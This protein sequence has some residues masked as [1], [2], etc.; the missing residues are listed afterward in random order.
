MDST[1]PRDV[2]IAVIGGSGLYS[3]DS[4][5]V[6]GEFEIPTPFGKPSDAITVASLHGTKIAFLARHGKGHH[7]NPSE[8]PSKANIAALKHIGVQVILAFSAVGSLREEIAPKDFVLPS[9]II[10][11]T[12][13]IRPSTF[14]EDGLV[15]H[16]MFADPFCKDISDLIYDVAIKIEGAPKIHH[17][18][19]I[20]CMEGP[21]FSTRA[22]SHMY[23]MF[24]GDVINMSV[25]P[26]AKLAREAEIVYQM[27]CMSTDYDCWKEHEE[28]VT[29]EQVMGNMKDN[30]IFAK[31][32]LAG[33]L[34][35][36]AAQVSDGMKCIKEIQNSSVWSVM[37]KG[38][39]KNLLTIEKIQYM[40]P[41]LKSHP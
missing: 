9:Q 29:V 4:L 11:R 28:A 32:L 24:G 21:H 37:T 23:R 7:L 16:V 34:P 38:E 6:I 17:S 31:K 39:K 22:E 18:K 36:L 14:F 26:E 33:V 20:I 1:F 13:G 10:D 3:L 40:L 12:K 19:T 5:E 30:A 25:V 2:K 15:A 41:L 8:V 27:I 35:I